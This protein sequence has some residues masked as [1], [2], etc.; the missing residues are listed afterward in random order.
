MDPRASSN[1][2]PQSDGHHGIAELVRCAVHRA[3]CVP[4]RTGE[5]A[6][7]ALEDLPW[8]ASRTA[9]RGA[10]PRAVGFGVAESLPGRGE[11]NRSQLPAG[12]E[13]RCRR[14]R[15]CID[16]SREVRK[17]QAPRIPQINIYLE[18]SYIS[19]LYECGEEG[20]TEPGYAGATLASLPRRGGS[21]LAYTPPF[22]R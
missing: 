9:A 6:N 11:C 5:R 8:C 3:S 17:L 4:W 7:S 19:F 22:C 15:G 2:T 12:C 20:A 18:C 16:P 10:A 14:A 13:P 21:A 1:L